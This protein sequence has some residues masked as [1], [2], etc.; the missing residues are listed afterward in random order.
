V[1]A[2]SRLGDAQIPRPGLIAQEGDVVYL[3]V[4]GDALAE[5]DARLAG[6]VKAGGH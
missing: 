2:V 5:I 1:A 4:H 3:A 6:P